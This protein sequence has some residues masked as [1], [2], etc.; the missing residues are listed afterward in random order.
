MCFLVA[1]REDRHV[2][3]VEGC[4]GVRALHA[5]L[6]K[7]R[8]ALLRFLVENGHR[9]E[10]QE[11]VVVPDAQGDDLPLVLRLEEHRVQGGRLQ[12]F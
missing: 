4:S 3:A 8:V 12:V 11:V 1:V 5:I 10:E 2:L 9:D 7:V 6:E